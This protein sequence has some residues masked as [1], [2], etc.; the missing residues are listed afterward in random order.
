MLKW[1]LFRERIRSF[2]AGVIH[3]NEIFPGCLGYIGNV[4]DEILPMQLYGDCYIN[5]DIIRIPI[6]QPEVHGK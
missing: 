4:G 1:Y 2:S 6:K 5:H 3:P